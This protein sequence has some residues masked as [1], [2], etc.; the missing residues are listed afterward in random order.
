MIKAKNQEI[1]MD[2]LMEK[3]RDN[4]AK[5]RK[6][7]I[8]LRS[9]FSSGGDTISSIN[10]PEIMA[11]LSMAEQNADAGSTILPMMRFW[12]PVRWLA[13]LVGRT[14]VY[15]AQV[16]TV[17][18]RRFNQSI[19]VA[20]RDT[21]DGIRSMNQGLTERD[22][23]IAGLEEGLTERD[24]R[25]AGLEEGL[26][27]RDNRIAGLEEGLVDRDNRIAGLEEGLKERDRSIMTSDKAISQIR[28]SM[29][30]QERRLAMLLEEAR[31]RLPEPFNHDQL[32]TIAGEEL[33]LLDPF[34]VSFEDQFRGSREDIKERFK[35]YLPL[36]KEVEAGTE[37][38]HILDVGCGRGE[39]L[40][41]L[42]EE[43]FHAKGIEINRVLIEKCRDYGIEV[44][45]GDAFECLRKISDASLGSVTA[46]HF[47]EHLSFWLLMKFLDEVV[48]V[49]KPGGIAI[50]ETPNPENII[51]GACNFYFDPTHRSPLP[52]GMMG[53][54]AESR[55][56]CRVEIKLLHPYGSE[57]KIQDDTSE[58]ARR[59]N[60]YF[61]GPQDYAVIGYKV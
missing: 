43:G 22:N 30:L 45:E 14:V 4:V 36:I 47:I 53:F 29:I 15:L 6:G 59:F 19:L 60:D 55:G 23:R 52:P 54:L 12:K 25:I 61:Y 5:R 58:L 50:F 20:L 42:K 34:Y 3:I 13:R 26:V 37:K 16:V 56:L 51:V 7:S 39:W 38:Q 28:T 40:E 9:N 18:Q 41:L 48:R 17:P 57:S 1:D 33:H 31:K 11:S 24:N 27:D 49:L 8:D 10:W 44:I 35:F 32:N 46:F 21:V 2:E